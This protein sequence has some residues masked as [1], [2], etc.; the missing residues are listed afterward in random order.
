[1]ADSQQLGFQGG[2]THFVNVKDY[3]FFATIVVRH[4]APY[5]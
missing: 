1:M 5:G 2:K 4:Y 3:I